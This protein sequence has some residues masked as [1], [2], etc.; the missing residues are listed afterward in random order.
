MAML[1][2]AGSA[3]ADIVVQPG[4]VEPG[5]R[6]VTLV[7]RMTDENPPARTVRLQV[8]LPLGRPLVGVSAPAPRGWTSQLTT[9]E[10][11]TPAPTADGPV[12]D[13]VASIDWKADARPGA[14]VVD[15]PVLV[16]L[17]PDGAGPVRF[18]AL[19]TDETGRIVE[20]S[21]TWADS[22]PPPAHD[23]LVVRLGSAPPPVV[24]VG[25]H[26]DHHGAEAAAAAVPVGAP[27]RAG[28]VAT[29][30]GLAALAAGVASLVTGLGRRQRRR[31][32]A[33]GAGGRREET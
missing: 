28:V 6:A 20:W 22:A 4:Q 27:T 16:D 12:R 5:A 33:T 13:V 25:T 1:L 23:A 9:A 30:S 24:T 10:L 15:L 21:N 3:A 2:G 18:R 14:A 8:F 11:A 19:A 32:E 7:F 17:M 31:F 29:V 26:G